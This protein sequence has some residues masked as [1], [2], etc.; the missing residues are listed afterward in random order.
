MIDTEVKKKKKKKS[1]EGTEKRKF[2]AVSFVVTY[3]PSLNCLDKMI[4][5]NTYLL[6]MNEDM[7]N[8]F[9]PWFHLE[10]RES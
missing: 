8:V 3:H 1:R 5:D 4:R 10:V 9:L 2:K 6:N 7:K